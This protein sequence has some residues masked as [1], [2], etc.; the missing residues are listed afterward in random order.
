[1]NNSNHKYQDR[2]QR[3]PTVR[4]DDSNLN[5]LLLLPESLVNTTV[6]FSKSYEAELKVDNGQEEGAN[7][8]KVFL[9]KDAYFES[10]SIWSHCSITCMSEETR[11]FGKKTKFENIFEHHKQ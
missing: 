10:W 5:C 4:I 3:D 6:F 8:A 2:K 9:K 1:M 7:G 11:A